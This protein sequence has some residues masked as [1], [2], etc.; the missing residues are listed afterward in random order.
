MSKNILITGASSGIG[1]GATQKFIKEKWKVYG[2]STTEEGVERL[3]KEFP[4][5]Y[6]LK[7]D[8]RDLKEIRYL[9]KEIDRLD[10]LVNN[11]GT[12]TSGK[13]EDITEEEYSRV[14]DINVKGPFNFMKFAIPIMK[15]QGYGK[16]INIASTVGTR[17][18]A[19]LSPYSA[20]K[21]AVVGLSHSVRDE[22]IRQG[23]NISVSTIYPGA[24]NTPFNDFN[25]EQMDVKDVVDAIYFTATRSDNSFVDLF[26]Y[27]KMEKRK[28]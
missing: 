9:F 6:F 2:T 20:S 3:K 12:K 7:C 16:I 19:F 26:I 15:N 13:I 21:H 27:P 23:T 8:V 4:E 11:A 5:N 25:P 24:T 10:V 1:Y 22:L 17:E 14:M 18:C 28:P